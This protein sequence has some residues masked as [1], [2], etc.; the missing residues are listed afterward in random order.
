MGDDGMLE[1]ARIL[2]LIWLS[3]PGTNIFHVMSIPMP[4]LSR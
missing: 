1:N 2:F 3:Y 4:L